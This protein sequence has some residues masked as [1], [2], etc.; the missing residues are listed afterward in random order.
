MERF[1]GA[2]ERLRLVKADLL[3]E[4]SFD[5]AVDGADGVFHTACPVYA[6]P[7]Q[8]IQVAGSCRRA[9]SNSCCIISY[10]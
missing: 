2:E 8:N 10:P 1:D 9:R 7:G 6:P 5:D 4:G 3:V